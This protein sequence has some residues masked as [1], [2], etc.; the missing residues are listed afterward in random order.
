[1]PT[2]KCKTCKKEFRPSKHYIDS[3]YCHHCRHLK[4]KTKCKN[5]GI[6]FHAIKKYKDSEY[7]S[8]CRKYH[9][10]CEI[11][12]KEIF[13]QAR[14]CSKECAY[15]LKKASWL[16]SCGTTHNFSK[17]S[18][19]R[20]NWEGRLKTE[21]GIDNVFQREEVKEKSKKSHLEK[22]GVENPS[23][24][25]IIKEQKAKTGLRNFGVKA[26]FVDIEKC[27]KTWFKKYGVK[28][29]SQCIEVK[30]RIRQKNEELG[31]WFPLSKLPELELY[32]YNVGIITREN[33]NR[34]GEKYLLTNA[35][36]LYQKNKNLKFKE[37][38]SVDHKFSVI[39]GFKNKIS[40][41]I[42][43][44]I[45]NLEIMTISE[46]SKKHKRCSV[47]RQK[48]INDYKNFLNENK[49]N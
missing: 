34:Y 49:I 29:P 47:T 44:S 8:S 45:I 5:C 20:K 12:G 19:S 35:K 36:E 3:L 33:I 16:K 22:L 14:T 25:K 43:G 21:E 46:N 7:C 11:C 30:K 48:L 15:E 39:E 23:Q 1:M 32:R 31:I 9:K 13:V 24:S 2:I 27:K 17:N 26:G 10:N 18:I 4:P 40:P 38:L 37:K 28:Y 6:E 41:E 42:I